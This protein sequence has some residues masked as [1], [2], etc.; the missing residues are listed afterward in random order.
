MEL[1]KRSTN[2][3]FLTQ[4]FI[5]FRLTPDISSLAIAIYLI[6]RDRVSAAPVLKRETHRVFLSSEEISSPKTYIFFL[7]HNLSLL[8]ITQLLENSSTA[9]GIAR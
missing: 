6:T 7:Y 1:C 2:G 5:T 4:A 8:S 3:Y 9:V